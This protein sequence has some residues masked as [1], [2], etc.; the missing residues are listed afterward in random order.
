MTSA[1]G[2]HDRHTN[3]LADRNDDFV[4]DGEQT[5]VL[6]LVFLAESRTI[7]SPSAD[8]LS[9]DERLSSDLYS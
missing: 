9:K 8:R 7:L 1:V 6:G 5:R 4:V 3:G 2:R